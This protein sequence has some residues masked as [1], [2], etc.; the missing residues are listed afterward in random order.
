[1]AWH[2]LILAIAKGVAT[3]LFAVPKLLAKWTTHGKTFSEFAHGKT[4]RP[5]QLC[6]VPSSGGK[7]ICK[8]LQRL[9]PGI[10]ACLSVGLRR[11]TRSKHHPW[12]GDNDLGA[13]PIGR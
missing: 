3:G 8:E 10:R 4:K 13:W 12:P 2:Y 7:V 5:H 9:P 1:M 6:F 11:A